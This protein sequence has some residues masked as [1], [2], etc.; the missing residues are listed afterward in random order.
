M[1]FHSQVK[2]VGILNN[3]YFKYVTWEKAAYLQSFSVTPSLGAIT[4][5]YL[6]LK[7]PHHSDR[8]RGFSLRSRILKKD[9]LAFNYRD[10]YDTSNV[11]ICSLFLRG[12]KN[13]QKELNKEKL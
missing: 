4:Q 12:E 9:R 11:I 10:Y 3:V 7:I 8:F 6:S 1:C 2:S 5:N 13:K